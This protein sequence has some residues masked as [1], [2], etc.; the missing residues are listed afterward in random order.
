M[1]YDRLRRIALNDAHLEA[2]LELEPTSLEPRVHA[3]VRLAALVAIGGAE[4][5]Y[6]SEVDEA[7]SAG[8]TTTEIVD[9]LATVAP[10]VG[11]PTVVSAGSK[12]A[13]ALGLDPFGPDPRE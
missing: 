4:P 8:V 3:L 2:E 7:I 1:S 13:L 5:S 11:L 10:I 6:G 12:V 9:V